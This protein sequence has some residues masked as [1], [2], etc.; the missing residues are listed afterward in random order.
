MSGT[1]QV[2]YGG[3]SGYCS[4]CRWMFGPALRARVCPCCGTKLRRRARA[5]LCRRSR[6]GNVRRVA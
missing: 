2:R 3:G 6:T 4:R 5:T 1:T